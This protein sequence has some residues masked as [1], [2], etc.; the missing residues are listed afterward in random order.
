MAGVG[1]TAQWLSQAF[2][3]L[4]LFLVGVSLAGSTMGAQMRDA[5]LR[6]GI[7]NRPVP[8]LAGAL[9]YAFG[10]SGLPLAVMVITAALPVGSNAFLFAQ[11]YGVVQETVTASV[12]VSSVVTAVTV[13]LILLVAVR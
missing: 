5:V 9:G 7:K 4:A 12:T 8:V 1:I 11:R 3:P 2:G 10:M 13:S 6:A